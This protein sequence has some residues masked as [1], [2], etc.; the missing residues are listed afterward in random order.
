MVYPEGFNE[1]QVPV[2]M[3][4]PESLSNGMTML[5]GKPTFLQVDTSQFATR[6]QESKALPP[7]SDLSPNPATHPMRALTLKVEGQTA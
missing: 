6:E 5:K 7:G 4:L 1:C 2:I 3:S